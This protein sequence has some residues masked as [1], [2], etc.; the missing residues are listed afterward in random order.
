MITNTNKIFF[1]IKI[2]SFS[3]LIWVFQDIYEINISRKSWNK[4]IYINNTLDI[5]VNRLLCAKAYLNSK[6]RR[7]HRRVNFPYNIIKCVD[8]SKYVDEIL[9]SY[10]SS[11]PTEYFER[12]YKELKNLAKE[13]ISY[14]YNA[15]LDSAYDEAVF[16]ELFLH[17]KSVM[18]SHNKTQNN[19][20]KDN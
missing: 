4:K 5:G 17:A 1:F 6:N 8:S 7:L 16:Y 14:K 11:I 20:G 15:F 19:T 10:D 12:L 9:N 18:D 3:L 2:F 13:K